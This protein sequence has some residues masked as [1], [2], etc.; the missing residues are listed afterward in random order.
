MEDNNDTANAY[1]LASMLF[2]NSGLTCLLI[3]AAMESDQTPEEQRNQ[4]RRERWMAY[5]P[6]ERR[7][8]ARCVPRIGT[9]P[10]LQSPWQML[11]SSKDN[12]SFLTATGVKRESFMALLKDFSPL[13]W[14][15]S[16][17]STEIDNG[18]I[19]TMEKTE[20]RG[21]A[22]K[23]SA[24]ACLGMV[25][26]WTR[27]TCYNWTI[28]TYFG[29]VA[30]S[31]SLWLRHGRRILL[32]VLRKTKEAEICMPDEEKLQQYKQAIS[33]KY[34]ALK[35]VSYV[36][37]GLKILIQRA[38]DFRKQNKFYNGWKSDHYITNL[39]LFGPDGTINACVLNCPGSMHDSELAMMGMP[40]IYSKIDEWH[41]KFGAQCVMDSAFCGSSR[42]SI[43]KSIPRE[44]VWSESCD[45]EEAL[46]LDQALSVR[47]AA[48]WG[49]RALQGSMPRLKTRWVYEEKDERMISLTL[50]CLIYNYRA[51]TT[52]LNQIRNVFMNPSS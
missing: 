42:N 5:T 7:M 3:C 36:A 25:L 13:F 48:E 40:S 35:H 26:F 21:R 46:V 9:L 38:G 30:S 50:I 22:R 14:A 19:R 16:P 41:D 10:P 39:F 37:D 20:R 8:R 1:L 33:D 28:A 18:R 6:H 12:Q 47:Q 23:M 45:P 11:Y 31:C 49:M 32:A 17:Y 34:P 43:I 29:I 4:R 52:D 44:R 2:P 51:N 15:H 24:H 27:T